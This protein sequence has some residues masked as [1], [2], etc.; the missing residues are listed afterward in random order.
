MEI[1]LAESG[2][3]GKPAGEICITLT[4]AFHLIESLYG[5]S[6]L[7]GDLLLVTA[8]VLPRL[9]LRLTCAT[10]FPVGVTGRIASPGVCRRFTRASLPSRG[11]GLARL[12]RGGE[13]G[14]TIVL[15]LRGCTPVARGVGGRLVATLILDQAVQ[16]VAARLRIVLATR[17][18]ASNRIELRC[19]KH[20]RQ[21]KSRE[22]RRQVNRVTNGG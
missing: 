22:L 21:Y 6:V 7:R 12:L 9:C 17:N 16:I 3:L 11:A 10:C 4:K 2:E 8:P 20:V 1:P 13:T 14:T 15:H 5:L 19:D 18:L